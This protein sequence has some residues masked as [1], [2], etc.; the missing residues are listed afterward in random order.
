MFCFSVAADGAVCDLDLW[1]P[2][3][4]YQPFENSGIQQQQEEHRETQSSSSQGDEMKVMWPSTGQSDENR[5][6]IYF[7][8]N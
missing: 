2:E 4:C 6:S 3:N 1:R 8:A 5:E 7:P